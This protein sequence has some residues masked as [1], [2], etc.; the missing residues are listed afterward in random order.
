MSTLTIE[1]VSAA[2]D[3]RPVLHDLSFN[4]GAGQVLGLIG[5]N[6][7]GKS[8]LLRLLSGTLR[9]THGTIRLDGK[10]LSSLTPATRARSIAV[11]PQTSQL[12]EAFSVG[13]V[14]LMGRTPYLSRFG[15]ERASDYQIAHRAMLQTE[16]WALAQ[17]RIG[18]LS[19]GEQ[20]RVLIARA[21]AQEPQVLLL[22]EA[23]AHL[24]LKYQVSTL[25][26]ARRLALGGMTIIAALHDLNL[27]AMF[28]DQL[29]LL[30]AGRIVVCDTPA[31]VLTPDW[32]R[33]VYGVEVVIGQHP[34]YDKP[35]LAFVNKDEPAR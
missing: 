6:G 33:Q 29:M 30:D 20:Q 24:D 8:T 21:L 12:P 16:T 15:G 10:L 26:L 14:V 11:V 17:R 7:S 1:H 25:Q 28:V 31:Q 9:A 32:I 5:P 34:W 22:D 13:E 19:G 35:L 3:Q 27:A 2:Y 4:V 23:T 18:E